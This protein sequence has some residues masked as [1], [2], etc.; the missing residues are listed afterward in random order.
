MMNDKNTQ[1]YSEYRYQKSITKESTKGN[2]ED[3]SSQ[4][5]GGKKGMSRE[6]AV[7]DLR[8]Y[9]KSMY[10]EE[11]FAMKDSK[12]AAEKITAAVLEYVKSEGISI[13]GIEK[14]AE[15]VT[16]AICQDILDFGILTP[17][18]YDHDRPQGSKIE[19]IEVND[20]DDVWITVNGKAYRDPSL[21]FTSPDQLQRIAERIVRTGNSS[22]VLKEDTPFVRVRLGNNIRVSIMRN[23]V[24]R[25]ALQSKAVT[26]M[27]IRKQSWDVIPKEKLIQWGTINEYGDSLIEM[28]V[29][30]G[31]RI[32]FYGGTSTGKTGTM[33][34][35]VVRI[36][37]D[38]RII[39][40]AEIDEM[41]ARLLDKDGKPLNRTI[42][43][44][45]VPE[46]FDLKKAVL[47]ALTFTPD[48]IIIQETKG[49]EAVEVINAG[50]TGHQVITTGHADDIKSVG[51][52]FVAMYKQSGS[53][54]DDEIILTM[55]ANAFDIAV[56]MERLGD[57]S[58]KIVNVSQILS[59]NKDKR[60]IETVPLVEYSVENNYEKDIIL[61]NG[62]PKT[63]MVYE[64]KHCIRNPISESLAKRL[65]LKGALKRNIERF[66]N[67]ELIK[68]EADYEAME[69]K[70]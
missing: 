70:K 15:T 29:S 7:N 5:K 24:A 21:T 60:V 52:R 25:N 44:E 35:Y 34:S 37:K 12:Q 20:W 49:E 39:T 66:S 41:N 55:M 48:G 1:T 17:L 26:H 9:L 67:L 6:D 61:D 18:I 23:P 63:V 50:I 54:L 45:M 40:V 59:Y 19:E 11:L 69:D 43:W 53:N 13:E 28:L 22:T 51:E 56:Q 38:R 36:P 33:T 8:E 64:G 47:S 65:I 46:I 31:A 10:A 32:L 4:V 58:R 16:E 30:A 57:G 27:T 62:Q 3:S 2:I 14:L 42:M 68:K